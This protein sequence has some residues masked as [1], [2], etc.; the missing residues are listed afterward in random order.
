MSRSAK[1]SASESARTQSASTPW[2]TCAP[3]RNAQ[4]ACC[5]SAR[6]VYEVLVPRRSTAGT[7]QSLMCG[8]HFRASRPSLAASGAVV[9]DADGVLVMPRSWEAD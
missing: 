6:P 5:C 8:H 3:Q 2:I 7:E 1:S 4:R 9:F